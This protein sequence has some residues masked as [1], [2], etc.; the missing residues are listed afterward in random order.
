MQLIAPHAGSSTTETLRRWCR[1]EASRR[2][3]QRRRPPVIGKG[4]SVQVVAD[5][6]AG[7]KV[8]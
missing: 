6:H 3:G 1:K 7:A 8:F 4:S 5:Y 2:A